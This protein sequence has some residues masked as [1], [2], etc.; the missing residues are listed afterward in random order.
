VNNDVQYV[1]GDLV[2]DP[3]WCRVM[4]GEKEFYLPK[5]S[6]PM[7]CERALAHCCLPASSVE[8]VRATRNPA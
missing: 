1:I 3:G 2:I 4:R 5:L 6:P 8:S 7:G